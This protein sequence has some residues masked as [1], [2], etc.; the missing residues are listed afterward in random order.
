MPGSCDQGEPGGVG[1]MVGGA[2]SEQHADA[3]RDLSVDVVLDELQPGSHL[4]QVQQSDPLLVGALPFG[5][6]GGRFEVEQTVADQQPDSGV[7]DRL[8]GAPGDQRGVGR[9][10]FARPEHRFWLGAV[11]LGDDL[12][13]VHHHHRQRDALCA[14]AL[15]DGVD[16]TLDGHAVNLSGR[17]RTGRGEPPLS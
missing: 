16:T 15:E 12:A 13:T 5:N 10:H 9:Q 4:E 11:S 8:G 2:F 1:R 7:G 17:S 3:V 6:V 14:G